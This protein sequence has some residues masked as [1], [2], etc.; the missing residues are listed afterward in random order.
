MAPGLSCWLSAA[1]LAGRLGWRCE[2]QAEK[3]LREVRGCLSPGQKQTLRDDA[4]QEGGQGQDAVFP[5]L[6]VSPTG[7]V[8]EQGEDEERGQ[9]LKLQK[10]KHLNFR[11]LKSQDLYRLCIK[12]A[13]CRELRG[14]VDSRWRAH[15]S[16]G[17]EGT[18][19]WRVLYKP[20]LDKRAGDLQWRLIHG[21]L[22]TGRLLHKI[23]PSISLECVFCSEE[24]TVFHAYSDCE[25]LEPLF[26]LLSNLLQSLGVLF[27]RLMFIFGVPCR[28]KHSNVCVINMNIGFF[29]F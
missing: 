15:L 23:D 19:E 9:I 4:A 2:R 11:V 13:H 22:A 14:R 28:Q 1:E 20:P 3:V 26:Q 17:E 29:R 12:S 8:E 7:V 24:E 18:P 16:L 10:M 27:T 5:E 21:I 6:L 25:R